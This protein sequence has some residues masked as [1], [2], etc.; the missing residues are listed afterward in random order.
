MRFAST[1]ALSSLLLVAACDADGLDSFGAGPSRPAVSVAK[2]VT[3]V[4]ATEL[5]GTWSCRELNPYPDQPL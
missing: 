2:R 3:M 1:A 5:V 4:S